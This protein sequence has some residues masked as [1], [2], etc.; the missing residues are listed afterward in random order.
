[1]KAS[2]GGVR[3]RC[4]ERSPQLSSYLGISQELLP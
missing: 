4:L 3:L 1:M 2:V